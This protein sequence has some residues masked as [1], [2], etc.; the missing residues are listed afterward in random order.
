[1]AQAKNGIIY[2]GPSL[3]DGKPIVV[4]ATWSKRNR[5]TGAFLQTYILRADIAPL[6]ASKS[7]EDF[8]ICGN[9]P[10]RG[11]P[12]TNPIKKQATERD[13][14]VF[15]GQGPTQ[16]YRAF[17]RGSYP[18][19]D[20]AELGRGRMVRLGAYGDPAACPQH[21]WDELLS[22]SAGWTGYTHQS[23]AMP[24][25]CMQSA[26]T[27]EQAQ[28]HWAENRRTFRVIQSVSE[29]VKGKEILCPASKE[30][31]ERVQCNACG[32]CAGTATRSPKSIA[33]VQH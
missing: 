32:L 6:A 27:L 17:L 20:I 8:S 10:M 33:I 14:Y 31:G 9:C 7:G 12:T 15:I 1:M 4:I 29:V 3:L 13:C 2:R 30:A 19:G 5:K 28:Y 18:T 25:Q 21:I 11:K 26:D 24:S 22:E 16:V 23:A